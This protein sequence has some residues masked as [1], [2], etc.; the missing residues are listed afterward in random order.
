[1]GAIFYMFNYKDYQRC[2]EYKDI[3]TSENIKVVKYF[4][5]ISDLYVSFTSFRMK[6]EEN[7]H[8][9]QNVKTSNHIWSFSLPTSRQLLPENVYILVKMTYCVI[10]ALPNNFGGGDTSCELDCIPI[11]PIL[12]LSVPP[13]QYGE[14]QLPDIDMC[15]V[16]IHAA[17]LQNSEPSV[18]PL[19]PWCSRGGS[20][21]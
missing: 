11:S 17:T 14:D 9:I 13:P 7:A 2:E 6:F 10:S 8:K 3:N 16:H 19:E 1:M 4:P 5:G 20:I 21:N 18:M 15:K 12:T